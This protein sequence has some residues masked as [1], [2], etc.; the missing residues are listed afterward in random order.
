TYFARR[1]VD[2]AHPVADPQVDV[3]LGIPGGLVDQ[4]VVLRGIAQEQVLGKR[5]TFVRRAGLVGE[6]RD[7][8]VVPAL[9]ELGD[10]RTGGQATSDDD[11][12]VALDRPPFS[13]VSARNSARVAG[14]S[15][16]RPSSRAVTVLAP[17]ARA[18]RTL[19]QV[20]SASITTPTP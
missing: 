7:R 20:C 8:P 17:S 1:E 2:G 16:I 19:M 12:A 14:S 6:E 13:R 5:R 3:V 18:P 15:R 11:D 9:A 4:R 10:E